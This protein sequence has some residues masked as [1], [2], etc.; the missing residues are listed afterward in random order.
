M[1]E[2]SVKIESEKQAGIPKHPFG[3]IRKR[4]APRR[5]SAAVRFDFRLYLYPTLLRNKGAWICRNFGKRARLVSFG[6]IHYHSA[7]VCPS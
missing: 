4:G 6:E 2:V 1:K 5:L 7:P 3:I